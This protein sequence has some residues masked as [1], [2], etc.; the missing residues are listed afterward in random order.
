[1]VG[2]FFFTLAEAR[3]SDASL[4]DTQKY[5]T[6]DLIWARDATEAEC[7]LICDRSFVPRYARQTLDGTGTSQLL[8]Q[9][10]AED[11]SFRD[12]RTL[13]SLA[14]A[15]QVDETFVDFTVAELADVAVAFDG[16][17]HRASG[18]IF[19]GGWRNVVAAYEYGLDAPI[20]AD[21]KEAALIRYRTWLNMRRSGIPDRVTSYTAVDGG[22]YRLA[23]PGAYA[24]GIPD[25]DAAYS[26]YSRRMRTG[27]QAMG[28]GP[29]PAG[30]TYSYNPQAYSLFHGKGGWPF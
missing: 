28:G 25:V 16:T 17:T 22:S 11:R 8:L 6:A 19:T 23:L 12:F 29:V 26:R 4:A 9:G 20:P 7:E 1:V 5:P 2:G 15:P 13:R 3:G 30:R 27:T 18:D 10:P 24:T 21:L 14:V